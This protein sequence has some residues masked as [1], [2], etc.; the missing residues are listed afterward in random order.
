[1]IWVKKGDV[2]DMMFINLDRWDGGQE[3]HPFHFHGH[4]VWVLGGFA[5]IFVI[6][7]RQALG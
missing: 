1:M 6:F 5:F 7:T 2:V 4:S 3:Q